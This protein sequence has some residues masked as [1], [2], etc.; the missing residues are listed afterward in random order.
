[1]ACLESSERKKLLECALNGHDWIQGSTHGYTYGYS[2]SM[3]AQ[4]NRTTTFVQICNK[5][6]IVESVTTYEKQ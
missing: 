3:D 5:C 4:G 6:G 1:M 2:G